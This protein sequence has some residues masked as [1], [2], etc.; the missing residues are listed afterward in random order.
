M[1]LIVDDDAAV[2]ASLAL[3][4]K[5]RG[6][7]TVAASSPAEALALV[8]DREISLVLSDMN[9]SRETTGEEGLALLAD[10][11]HRRPTLPVLLI[12]AW[13][14]I[15]LAVQGMKGGA[16]DFITKPWS[17]EQ[18]IQAVETAMGLAASGTAPSEETSRADL[19]LEYDLAG[20]VGED[21]KFCRA[22]QLLMRVARTNAGILITGETGT[23]KEVVAE[24]VHRNS[25]RA[26]RSFVKVNLGGMPRSLF[27]SEMFGHVRG[28]FTDA[29]ADRP[30]RFEAARGGSI[31]LDEIGDLDLSCQV[32]LLRVL[33]DRSYEVLGTS[34]PRPLDVRVLCATNVDLQQAIAAGTFREDLYYRINLI[35]ARLPSLN[36]RAGDI[37]L[38]ARHFA[39]QAAERYS[40]GEVA[41]DADA[42]E[43]LKTRAW[44][45]NLRQLDHL[46]ER[47]LLTSGTRRL[48]TETLRRTLQA[49]SGE[50]MRDQL[51]PVGSMTMD[52]IERAM[53]L[54]SLKHHDGN[55]T[56]A[57]TALGMSRP[58]LYRRLDKH[59]IEA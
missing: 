11:R 21:P 15:N 39:T 24:A 55:I 28:A 57:A 32:K 14:S 46:V 51:P 1:I 47:T 7:A 31:L 56:R 5:Q 45:G 49:E 20:V 13:G 22:L 2:V 23:G 44:P 59:G 34:V 40:L 29:H 54:K 16:S 26:G 58:A 33:Q 36:E 38:L 18:V 53:I 17:N 3:L 52:E 27:E 42:L 4:L 25:P 48:S 43:W 50:D 37:P 35:E 19:D 41:V 6:H 10:I 12:T 8:D 30:G 9:F